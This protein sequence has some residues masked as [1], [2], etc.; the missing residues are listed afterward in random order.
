[1]KKIFVAICFCCY[2]SNLHA[3]ETESETLMPQAV[4][5]KPVCDDAAFKQKVMATIENYFDKQELMTSIA[6]RKK[7]LKLKG[8]HDFENVDVS[9]FQ[10]EQNYVVSKALIELK[11]NKRL[12]D[13]D[14]LL[15]RQRG[16]VSMPVY[17]VAYQE[18]GRYRVHLVN[19]DDH[20]TDYEKISFIYP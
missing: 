9:T 10:P 6:N 12:K 8:L 2:V 3:Q 17:V 16:K 13:D 19:L 1:M 7:M 14:I 18:N 4:I 20:V 15:C 5:Q 11:I